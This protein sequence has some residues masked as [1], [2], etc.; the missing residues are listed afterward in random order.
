M[1]SSLSHSVSTELAKRDPMDP[2][3]PHPLPAFPGERGNPKSLLAVA[4]WNERASVR[5]K[6]KGDH[7]S[8]KRHRA[9]AQQLRKEARQ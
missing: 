7:K 5:A 8:A 1:Q 2:T 3:F 9:Q 6:R 4:A